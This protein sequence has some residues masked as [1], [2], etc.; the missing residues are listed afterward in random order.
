MAQDLELALRI[1]ADLK[2]AV[3]QVRRFR[4]EMLGMGRQ[5][6]RSGKSLNAAFE[7]LGM[8]S[9]A[10]IRREIQAVRAA[11]ARLA[12]SGRLS[13]RELD[14][15]HQRM[16]A[17]IADLSRELK[18]A[19]G[20]AHDLTRGIISLGGVMASIRV[21]KGI[22]DASV[23]YQ[24]L[25]A[26]LKTVTGSQQAAN[27]EFQ[28]LL[29]FAT[30]TP[31]SLQEVL[32]AFVKLKALGLDPSTEALRSYGNT[33]AAMGKSLDQFIEAVADAAT[34]EFERLKEFGIKARVE[35]DKVALTFRGTTTVVR[36]SAGDIVSYLQR[37][38]NV[39]FAGGMAEQMDTLGGKLANLEDAT[40]KFQ[41]ALGEGGFIDVVTTAVEKLTELVERIGAAREAMGGW[42]GGLVT[43]AITS[44]EEEADPAATIERLSKSLAVMKRD[45]EV[46]S[47]PTLRNKINELVSGNVSTLKAQIATVEAKIAYLKSLQAQSEEPP[48]QPAV[49]ASPGASPTPAAPS[50]DF[51]KAQADLERRIALLGRESAEQQMLWEVEKGRYKDLAEGEKKALIEMARRLDAGTVAI[52]QAEEQRKAEEAARLEQE[53]YDQELERAARAIRDMLDPMESQRRELA[54]LDELLARG[55]LSWDEWAEATLRVHERMDELHSKVEE[56]G[57]KSN[58]YAIQ[59]ARNI[60][61]AFADFLFDPF[62]DGLKGMLRGFA[63]I[64]RRMIAEAMAARLAEKLFGDFAKTG[65]LGGWIGGVLNAVVHHSGGIAGSSAAPVRA[66]SPLAFAG[67]PRYHSGGIAGLAP[68]EVPAI[69]RRGEEVLTADDPRHRANGGGQGVGVRI[70]NVIDPALAADYLNSSAGERVVLNVL[71]RNA[72]AIKQILV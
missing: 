8:R 34:G 46:L 62:E 48:K 15:A 59:A 69:L 28:R 10:S 44:G 49:G 18:G 43:W 57:T 58:E 37:I 67:A 45:L 64:I 17:R 11:Y 19:E 51:L 71:Q 65:L 50:D 47:R 14:T 16:R 13:A 27:A 1:K 56:T 52:R 33:A 55:K 32:G 39:E 12:D 22:I 68:D 24:R 30:Q 72:G 66:I 31:Y 60:Q 2:Q 61:S 3:D 63:D 54:Q 26:S 42:L 21:A 36:N 40:F 53:R 23:E 25:N 7:R 20:G 35:G 70:I 41:V 9:F 6:E 4:D 29:E 5:G 38:G